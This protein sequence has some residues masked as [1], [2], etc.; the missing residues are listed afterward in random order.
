M[1]VRLVSHT[2]PTAEFIEEGI[3]DLT[4]LVAFCAR[5]SNPSNQYNNE[6]ADKLIAYLLAHK[7]FSP[8]EMVNACLEIETTRDIAR[9]ILRH[10]SFRFQEFSQRYADPVNELEF[11][12]REA[13]FQDP[14]NRQNSISLDLTNAE[15]VQIAKEWLDKQQ[16][17][18]DLCKDTYSWA[19]SNNIAKEQAR[20]ILPEG[21]TKSRMYMNGTIR[22]WIHY[23]DVRA[24]ESTQL[25]HRLIALECARVI[26]TIFQLPA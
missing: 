19:R 10:V 17:I 2:T 4:G 14:V 13:R 25:E 12:L 1:K 16:A 3:T 5:V 21:L 26:S 11:E 7:H 20:V 9:Q 8:F 6:T 22:S 24:D 23:I 15:H 18:I